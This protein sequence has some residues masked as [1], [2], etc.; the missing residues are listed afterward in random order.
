MIFIAYDFEAFVGTSG[1]YIGLFLGY[2]LLQVPGMLLYLVTW[3]RNLFFKWNKGNVRSVMM[4]KMAET[5]E[6][7]STD[8]DLSGVG[9][10]SIP[11]DIRF[12]EYPQN[13]Y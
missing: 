13:C 7:T 11:D 3:C 5:N 10:P 9:P 1:G 6:K 8:Q 2:A 4:N 12:F